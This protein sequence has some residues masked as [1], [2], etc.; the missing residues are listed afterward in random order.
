[1]VQ[2]ENVTTDAPKNI[3]LGVTDNDGDD[4]E[5]RIT[6]FPTNGSIGGV[7]YNATHTTYEAVYDSG[8]EFGDE[9]DFGDGGR[10]SS[11]QDFHSEG[12]SVWVWW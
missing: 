5:V 10:R 3:T 9:I 6:T 7:I 8:V 12:D 2:T 11:N 1:M 4:V